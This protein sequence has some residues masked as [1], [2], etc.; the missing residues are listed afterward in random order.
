MGLILLSFANHALKSN[1]SMGAGSVVQVQRVCVFTQIVGG[2]IFNE[3]R[4]L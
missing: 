4:F 2:I 1:Y 3:M